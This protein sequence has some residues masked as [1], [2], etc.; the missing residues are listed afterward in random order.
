[1]LDDKCQERKFWKCERVGILLFIG[2]EA[3]LPKQRDQPKKPCDIFLKRRNNM[4]E[5]HQIGLCVNNQK[6]K[7]KRHSDNR[8]HKDKGATDGDEH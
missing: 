6:K 2:S 7:R 4:I 5:I 3:W 8:Q 1:M